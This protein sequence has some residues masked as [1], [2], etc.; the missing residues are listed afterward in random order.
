MDPNLRLFLIICMTAV[1]AVLGAIFSKHIKDGGS[2]WYYLIFAAPLP[3]IGWAL[4]CKY[5]PWSMFY[6]SMVWSVVYEFVWL[7][8]SVFILHQASSNYQVVGGIVT[9]I[10]LVLMGL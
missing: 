6:S 8:V 4:M 1:A 10:G 7:G 5:S 2:M 3:P 9:I